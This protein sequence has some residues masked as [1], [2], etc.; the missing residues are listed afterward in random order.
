MHKPLHSHRHHRPGIPGRQRRAAAALL[1]ALL[2]TG[3][4]AA[5][6]I[7]EKQIRQ[8]IQATDAAAQQR[9]TGRIGD[10]LSED[11]QRIIEFPHQ[12][13]MAKVKLDKQKY[14]EL[15]DA[16]WD[17]AESYRYHRGETVIHVMPDGVSGLS[18][19]TVTE[20]VTQDGDS[21]VS[22]FR[23]HAFYALEDGQVVITRIS[24]HTLVGDTTPASGQ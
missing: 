8:V 15:I 16:G 19:S 17:S 9:D 24:G 11:F 6:P 2:A 1:A 7:T 22:R 23:E 10:Y 5:D 14:L 4:W 13:L 18:Y 21:M 20:N 12:H 3:S